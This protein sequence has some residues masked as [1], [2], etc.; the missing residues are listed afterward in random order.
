MFAFGTGP[1]DFGH[2]TSWK[3]RKLLKSVATHFPTRGSDSE[4]V[5]QES[6]YQAPGWHQFWAMPPT[7][8]YTVS[9][10]QSLSCKSSGCCCRLCLWAG[11][12]GPGPSHLVLWL[13]ANQCQIF[14]FGYFASLLLSSGLLLWM[15]RLFFMATTQKFIGSVL[16]HCWDLLAPSW[17]I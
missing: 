16:W 14:H 3:C 15:P 1:V 10:Q 13:L 4:G 5:L 2:C 17:I 11:A 9:S 12:C 7:V 6:S 8:A